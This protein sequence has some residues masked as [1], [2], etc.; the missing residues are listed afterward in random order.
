MSLLLIE[1][2]LVMKLTQQETLETGEGGSG[3]AGL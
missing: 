3:E 1:L 2:P